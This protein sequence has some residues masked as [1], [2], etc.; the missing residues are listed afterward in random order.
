VR[1]PALEDVK[2]AVSDSSQTRLALSATLEN[3]QIRCIPSTIYAFAAVIFPNPITPREHSPHGVNVRT[4]LRWRTRGPN[5]RQREPNAFPFF[6]PIID[7]TFTHQPQLYPYASLQTRHFWRGA[8]WWGCWS[9]LRDRQHMNNHPR[10]DCVRRLCLLPAKVPL[11]PTRK[12][13]DIHTRQWPPNPT[14]RSP[15]CR[16]TTRPACSTSP[17]ASSSRMCACSRPAVHPR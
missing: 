8:Q 2:T 14:R 11:L 3:A 5:I 4:L 6:H 1:V 13:R 7:L 16:S 9:N 15:S 17:R 10:S 12:R